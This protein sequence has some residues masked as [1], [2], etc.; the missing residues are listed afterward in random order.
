MNNKVICR[1]CEWV[2]ITEELLVAPNPFSILET[3]YGCP[4]CLTPNSMITACEYEG[5]NKKA[6][7][8]DT[9]SE[10]SENSYE[11]E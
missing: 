9:C 10:H 11:E 6:V 4:L 8:G 5:C 3:I 1:E 7:C 2:G